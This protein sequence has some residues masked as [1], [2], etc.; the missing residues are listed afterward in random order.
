[1]EKPEKYQRQRAKKRIYVD[2]NTG[3][4]LPWHEILNLIPSWQD[5][6]NAPDVI[7]WPSATAVPWTCTWERSTRLELLSVMSAAVR[8]SISR[9]TRRFCTS[10]N[11]RMKRKAN[12]L[13]FFSCVQA[14]QDLL[15]PSLQ[16]QVLHTGGSGKASSKGE[17]RIG[18]N[19]LC[20]NIVFVKLNLSHQDQLMMQTFHGWPK[21]VNLVS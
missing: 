2:S 15:V 18:E 1:M 20:T 12:Y 3:Q 5:R 4:H 11:Y 17:I 8:S 9:G 10:E 13:T 7:Q 19:S 21:A 6:S 14:I 16:W